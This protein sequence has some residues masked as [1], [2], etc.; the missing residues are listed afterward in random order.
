MSGEKRRQEIFKY[1][2]SSDKPVS[3]TALAEQFQVSRQVI[4]QDIALIRAE[5]KEILSTNRG[6]IC[7]EK[8]ET[9]RVFHV[10]HDNDRILEELYLI[11]DQGGRAQDVFVQHAVYGEIRAELAVDSRKKASDFMENIEVGK[12][13][14]LNNITSGYHFHTVLAESEE[15]L[16]MIEAKLKENGFLV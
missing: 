1:I 10:F 5:G 4:V 16:D 12:S 9:S 15:I 13:S 14:P 3:G 6:Y 2:I 8:K 11:V 7:R